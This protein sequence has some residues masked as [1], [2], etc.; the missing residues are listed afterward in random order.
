[1]HL[2]TWE[3]SYIGILILVLNI[4]TKRYIA[5]KCEA[6]APRDFIKLTMVFTC[7]C[8]TMRITLMT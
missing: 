2:M 3:L 6:L 5:L 7:I 1:M 8:F 4:A